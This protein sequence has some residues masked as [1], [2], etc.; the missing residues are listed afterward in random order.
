MKTE[1]VLIS[2][3]SININIIYIIILHGLMKKINRRYTWT[4]LKNANGNT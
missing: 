3:N 2:I 1:E 4:V